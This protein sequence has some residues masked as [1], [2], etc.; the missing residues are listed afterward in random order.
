MQVVGAFTAAEVYVAPA[1]IERNMAFGRDVARGGIIRDQVTMEIIVR[2]LNLHVVV[3][4]VNLACLLTLT[5]VNDDRMLFADRH[6]HFLVVLR[7]CRTGSPAGA[8]RV[9]VDAACATEAEK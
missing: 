3:Q 7:C 9:A 4:S 5:R 8:G 1:A 6:P 2:E